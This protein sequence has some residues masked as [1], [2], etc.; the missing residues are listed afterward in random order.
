M[1]IKLRLL[2]NNNLI[3]NI[4]LQPASDILVLN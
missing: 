1:M 4:K 2:N 3:M